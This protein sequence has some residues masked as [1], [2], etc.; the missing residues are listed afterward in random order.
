MFFRFFGVKKKMLC[1]GKGKKKLCSSDSPFKSLRSRKI[2]DGFGRVDGRGAGFVSLRRM[3]ICA[4]NKEYSVEEERTDSLA[5]GRAT[6]RQTVH[7]TVCLDGPFESVHDDKKSN[8]G[9]CW[10]FVAVLNSSML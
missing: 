8:T 7:W 6:S 2:A 1:F 4:Q 9:R 3:R 10:T 5:C